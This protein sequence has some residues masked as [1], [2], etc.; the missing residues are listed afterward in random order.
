[1][2]FPRLPARFKPLP[3]VA[4]LMTLHAGAQ[5]QVL[6]P[7][8]AFP[9]TFQP[10]LCAFNQ[11]SGNTI[12]SNCQ[13]SYM[14]YLPWSAGNVTVDA[15]VTVSSSQVSI[16]LD[17]TAE[18]AV[19]W[20]NNG[21]IRGSSQG[22]MPALYAWSD[23]ESHF[24]FVNN[25][26]FTDN[27]TLH[28]YTGTIGLLANNGEWDAQTTYYSPIVNYS[29]G[30]INTLT[31]T[32]TIRSAAKSDVI[33]NY[34]VINTLNNEGLI[35]SELGIG[36]VNGFEAPAR[37]VTLNNLQGGDTPL[38]FSGRL[39]ENYNVIIRSPSQ[40][41]KLLVVQPTLESPEAV[42]TPAPAAPLFGTMRFGIAQGST[43]TST[44]YASVLSGLSATDLG[45]ALTGNY[46]GFRWA[47]TDTDDNQVWDLVM[48]LNAVAANAVAQRTPVAAGAA[49]VIDAN[50]ALLDLFGNVQGDATTLNTAVTQTLPFL[51]GGSATL[52][53]GAMGRINQVIQG[54]FDANRGASA[55]NSYFG[56]GSIWFKPFGGKTI[57][58][59]VGGTPGYKANLYGL[60]GG[61]EG[62]ASPATRL[63][64][65]YAYAQSDMGG[66]GATSPQSGQ[67]I[68]RQI[69]GYG[70]HNLDARTSVDFQADLGMNRNTTRRFMAFAGATAT[71]SYE[72]STAH[73]G[74]GIQRSYSLADG[75]KVSP[76]AR[77]DYTLVEDDAYTEGGAGLLNLSVD[78]KRTESY[79]STLGAS[80]QRA[81]NERSSL[82]ARAGIGYDH[83]HG[84]GVLTAAYAGAPTASFTTSGALPAPWLATL[85]LGLSWRTLGGPELLTQY[86]LELREKFTNQTVSFKLRWAF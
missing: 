41:G 21:T 78:A 2:L 8:P 74:L 22:Y 29:N 10:T 63:G 77:I 66:R 57:Q 19:T 55:G 7:V 6:L 49:S 37:I 3:A 11:A 33:R 59:D 86:D 26:T 31:N 5:A 28:N 73:L 65:A 32:G 71:A 47:L 36:I 61:V 30:V 40:Y 9:I 56:N 85:G 23:D 24:N 81:L 46:N 62:D 43:V 70:T 48:S 84:K 16:D 27:A 58:G 51:A 34:G 20:T 53:Q 12:S 83:S 50:S 52:T 42:L 25:G 82:I 75:L 15:G 76:F 64:L 1:M 17:N 35:L 4:L 38:T 68:V 39:P 13:A 14:S 60:S 18:T 69:I 80:L 44:T 72:S 54:R 45:N 79:V 67:T